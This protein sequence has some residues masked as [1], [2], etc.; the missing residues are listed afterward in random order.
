MASGAVMPS[1]SQTTFAPS[2]MASSTIGGTS[3][4]RRKTFTI[5]SGARSAASASEAAHGLPS[6]SSQDGFTGVMS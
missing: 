6:T 2:A 4:G 1:W 3:A 5:S